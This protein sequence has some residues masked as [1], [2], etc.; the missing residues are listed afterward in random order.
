M[1]QA[2]LYFDYKLSANK[3]CSQDE[4]T[5]TLPEK[6]K[7]DIMLAQFRNFVERSILFRTERGHIDITLAQ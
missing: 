1:S 5:G 3:I 6:L 4:I 7:Q 2:N